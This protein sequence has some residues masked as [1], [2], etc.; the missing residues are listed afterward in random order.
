MDL[1]LWRYPSESDLEW[2]PTF[3]SLRRCIRLILRKGA[4]LRRWNLRC[5]V[6]R[7]GIFLAAHLR[8]LP[9]QIANASLRK[10]Q[11][12]GP[13]K[14]VPHVALPVLIVTAKPR[15]LKFVGE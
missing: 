2:I 7:V 14:S 8:A 5:C 3:S 1:F 15:K 10:L 13:G 9:V 6:R 12:V 4:P 11:F